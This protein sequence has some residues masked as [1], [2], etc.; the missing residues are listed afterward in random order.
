MHR[1]RLLH[2]YVN[3]FKQKIRSLCIILIMFKNF[4]CRAQY[5]Q[6]IIHDKYKDNISAH[7]KHTN[8]NC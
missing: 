1:P 7:T 6:L 3:K 4:I 2:Y 8:E 5:T